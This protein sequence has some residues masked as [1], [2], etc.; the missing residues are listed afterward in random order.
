MAMKA[1]IASAT[2]LVDTVS[3]SLADDIFSCALKRQTGVTLRHMLDFGSNP[4]DRQL[5]LS[6]QF[7]RAELPIRWDGSAG[8]PLGIAVDQ[9]RRGLIRCLYVQFVQR[10]SQTPLPFMHRSLGV[11]SDSLRT[12]DCFTAT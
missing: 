12:G 2:K 7:L 4:V 10:P 8:N 6:A 5:V 9:T 1:N 3:R 11:E